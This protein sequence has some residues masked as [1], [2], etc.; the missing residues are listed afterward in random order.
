M[1]LKANNSD[2][3]R[4]CFL[5][6]SL[7]SPRARVLWGIILNS[8]PQQSKLS[9]SQELE[10]NSKLYFYLQFSWQIV[11]LMFGILFPFTI[12]Y[13]WLV[14][15]FAELRVYTGFWVGDINSNRLLYIM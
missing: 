14:L 4:N 6:K 1:L 12:F 13:L 2:C 3:R 11:K 15:H 9:R 10:L 7:Q 5:N 8:S